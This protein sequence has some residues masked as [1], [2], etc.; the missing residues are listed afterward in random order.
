MVLL[1][2][3]KEQQLDELTRIVAG[4]CLF[5]KASMN[6]EFLHASFPV[7]FD[8]IEN[9]LIASQ[10][11]GG[12][13]TSLLEELLPPANQGVGCD[14]P[15]DLLK[16][17]LY[18]VRQH[19]AFLKILLV[20]ES[21]SRERQAKALEWINSYKSVCSA[22][23]QSNAHQCASSTGDLRAKLLAQTNLL[24]ESVRAK[25]AVHTAQVFVSASIT[26]QT[27]QLPV[28]HLCAESATVN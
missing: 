13:Y 1:Q 21:V 14:V 2:K 23:P 4:I 19:E 22:Y 3:D 25:R 20:S 8:G 9:E 7:S 17:A 24:K 15:I 5:N 28:A 6:E 16:Q 18:N 27:H 12:K 11:L 10:R 26:K